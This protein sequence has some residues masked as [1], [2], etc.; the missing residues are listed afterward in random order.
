MSEAAACYAAMEA[1]RKRREEEEKKHQEEMTRHRERWQKGASPFQNDQECN[2]YILTNSSKTEVFVKQ[3]EFAIEKAEKFLNETEKRLMDLAK[4]HGEDFRVYRPYV[5]ND[6]TLQ[7]YFYYTGSDNWI[8]RVVIQ[9]KDKLSLIWY[10]RWYSELVELGE[11]VTAKQEYECG[12]ED[13]YGRFFD[14]IENKAI[15]SIKR[16]RRDLKKREIQDAAKWGD[17]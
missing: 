5:S 3:M 4:I 7:L 12:S 10:V 15:P 11:R 6:L 9:V 2:E 17:A 8:G 16:K 14:L 13:D 1:A